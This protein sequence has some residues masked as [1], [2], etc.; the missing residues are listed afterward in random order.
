MKISG[1]VKKVELLRGGISVII[2]PVSGPIEGDPYFM[3]RPRGTF[4]VLG[5]ADEEGKKFKAGQSVEIEINPEV[6]TPTP[7]VKPKG[8]LYVDTDGVD[9]D[10][11]YGADGEGVTGD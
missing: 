7:E 11:G 10:F 6:A 9:G 1:I 3:G 5:L 2:D 8:E 4:E